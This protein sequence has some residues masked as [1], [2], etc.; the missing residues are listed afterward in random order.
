MEIADLVEA[1]LRACGFTIMS[2]DGN[3]RSQ[4]LRV[5]SGQLY[6]TIRISDHPVASRSRKHT[7]ATTFIGVAGGVAWFDAIAWLATKAGLPIS[8]GLQRHGRAANR[9]WAA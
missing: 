6:Q 5:L 2:R 1:E 3:P 7:G 4:Y 9:S 8:P